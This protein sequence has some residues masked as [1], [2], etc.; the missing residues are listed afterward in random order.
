M[1]TGKDDLTKH[2][3]LGYNIG[4]PGCPDC[5]DGDGRYRQYELGF[6]DG[7][8]YSGKDDVV[9]K[10]SPHEMYGFFLRNQSV[11]TEEGKKINGWTA[12]KACMGKKGSVPANCD[13]LTY[14]DKMYEDDWTANNAITLLQRRPKEKPFFLHVSFPGPHPPF[15]V[16]ASMRASA[17]DGRVWPSAQDDP[18]GITPGGP[19]NNTGEPDSTRIRCNYAAELE[20]LDD[21]F[22]QILNEVDR[23]GVRD[24][25][26]VCISSDHGEMLGDHGDVDKSKPWE[27]AAHVPL[28]CSGP[29][30]AMNQTHRGPVATMDMAGTFLDFAGTK[31]IEG[32][33][34]RSFRPL[35][36]HPD[37]GG[38][39]PVDPDAYRTTV[40]S[41]LLNF[42]MNV[43][44]NA[45]D[46][47]TYKYICCK[48][49]CPAPPSNAPPVDKSGWMQMLIA[50][51]NDPFD[52]NDLSLSK[53][54][55]VRA[56]RALLPPEYASGCANIKT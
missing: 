55:V 29:G 12:H 39:A 5:V 21:L 37:Q 2:S 40:N 33:S 4:Y 6:S 10:N 32:M 1:T 22:H 47:V 50:P 18:K 49:K 46:N 44:I 25:T 53:P 45:A 41:G 43:Q 16:T 30:I 24:N 28:I 48:G 52:M 23:Q 38:S 56:M 31:P 54:D 17:S 3:Q 42:R 19:C 20:N 13:K 14:N 8:R 27:G 9:Q 36:E 34:T 11:T 51:E 15:L 7:L 35:L 26:V